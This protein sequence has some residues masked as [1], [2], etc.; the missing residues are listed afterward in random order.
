M[1]A[2][3]HAD[4][5]AADRGAMRPRPA[6]SQAERDEDRIEFPQGREVAEAA[7]DLAA[8]ELIAEELAEIGLPVPPGQA[9][10][11]ARRVREELLLILVAP[12]GPG[13]CPVVVIA[14]DGVDVGVPLP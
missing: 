6:W 10:D 12:A 4:L 8:E 5:L 3:D 7:A 9:V 2:A 11:D 1:S 13:A 14:A